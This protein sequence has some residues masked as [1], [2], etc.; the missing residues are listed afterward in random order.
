MNGRMYDATLG[1]F[2]SADTFIQAPDN[3][4]SFNRYSYVLNNPMKYNDP[5]GH[6]F[7]KL[8]KSIKKHW[9][10]VAAIAI[11]VVAPYAAAYMLT[12]GSIAAAGGWA[13]AIGA[14]SAGQL[15][16]V[17]FVAGAIGG[18]I[19]GRSFK[20]A[21]LGGIAGAAFGAMHAWNPMGSEMALKAIAHGVAGGFS[22]V[23]Q[24]G[25][26]GDGFISAFSTQAFTLAGGFEALGATGSQRLGQKLYN[27]MISAVVGGTVSSL[28]GGKF[29][30]GAVSGAFSR[31][32]N[33]TIQDKL[34]VAKYSR[35]VEKQVFKDG[36]PVQEVR[37]V[38]TGWV[39]IEGAN[40]F[41]AKVI[42]KN[43]NVELSVL[44]QQSK[45]FN[46]YE[47][48]VYYETYGLKDGKLLEISDLQ[49]TN[50]FRWRPTG[51]VI[52]SKI[53]DFRICPL[54]CTVINLRGAL[55]HE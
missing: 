45:V 17:G 51:Q 44:E 4:Q 14:L 3:S 34:G 26:F 22:S 12:V 39:A 28:S 6:F 37:P 54:N 27:A 10:T 8:F 55:G 32:L 46:L 15:A 52:Q 18:A 50:N 19:T 43:L 42:G 29:E 21:L 53:I 47:E 41:L 23:M 2:V 1:R 31:M 36:M 13:A 49:P 24:G 16:A 48:N 25:Q 30:N 35:V 7:K 33:D 38:K 5:S 40:D 9:R 11:A 20:S